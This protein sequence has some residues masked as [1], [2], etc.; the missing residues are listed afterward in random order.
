MKDA[1]CLTPLNLAKV[2][3][4]N[5]TVKMVRDAEYLASEC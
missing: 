5:T 3:I 2:N 1:W 4:W